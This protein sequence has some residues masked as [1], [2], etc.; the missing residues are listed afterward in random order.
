MTQDKGLLLVLSGPS[1][2]GKGTVCAALRPQM[3]DLVY[4]VSATTRAPRQGEIDGVNYF[5]KSRD[6]FESMIE[7]DQMLEWAEYVGNFYGTPRQ[8]VEETLEQGKDVILEIE[9]Q[10]ALQ[11][12]EK[13]PEGI[14]I[15]LAPPDLKELHSRITG[16]GTETEDSIR[17]RMLVARAE[18]ELMDYYN[19]VVVN[20]EVE[21]AC[22]RIQAIVVA[23]HLKK[24]RQIAKYRNWIE[25]VF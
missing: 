1:G 21:K 19:Y 12:K 18:I 17:N 22:E 9:V 25:E 20:D 23:E 6:E 5:F 24:E 8:F 13:F 10:G 14:F 15:F 4:S 2:V 7:H 3:R 11:V 16:R